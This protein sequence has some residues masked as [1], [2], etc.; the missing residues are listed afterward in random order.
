[1]VSVASDGNNDVLLA[2]EHVRHRRTALLRRHVDRADFFTACLVVSAQHSASLAIRSREH[3]GLTSDQQRLGNESS[4][5]AR[6]ARSRNV[7]TF[8]RWMILYV[9]RCFAMRNLPQDLAFV[10]I[11]GG[12]SSVRRLCQR[13]SLNG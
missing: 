12:D 11:N 8:Q 9:V 3:T 2:V 6:P 1:A 10:Q 5:S 7:Q 13:Q 4:D